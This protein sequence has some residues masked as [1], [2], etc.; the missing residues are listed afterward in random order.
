M[1]ETDPRKLGGDIAGPGGPFDEHGV[2]VDTRRAILM[3][4]LGIVKLDNPDDEGE[5]VVGVL[6]EGKINQSD[7]RASVLVLGDLDMLAAFI[8]EAHD[9][10]NRMGRGDELFDLCEAR[11]MKMP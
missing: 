7:D 11:W 8:T 5:L 3:D 6:I 10:A 1:S 9:L 2:V 4:T